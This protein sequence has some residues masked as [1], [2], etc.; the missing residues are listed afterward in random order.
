MELLN[1][2]TTR[3]LPA[4]GSGLLASRSSRLLPSQ[5]SCARGRAPSSS[6]TPRSSSRLCSRRFDHLPESS[7]PH[8]RRRGPTCLSK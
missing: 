8:T 3:W 7:R 4:T 1:R 5:L 6:T 2:C